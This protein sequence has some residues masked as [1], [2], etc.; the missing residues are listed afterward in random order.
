MRRLASLLLLGL[1]LTGCAAGT[2]NP[3][4]QPNPGPGTQ[5]P[6]PVGGGSTTPAPQPQTPAQTEAAVKAQAVAVLKAIAAND[7]DALSALTHPDKGLR[8]SPYGYVHVGGQDP[9]RV[10][11]AAQIKNAYG[12]TTLLRWGYAD[13]SGEPID[14]SFSQY[15]GGYVNVRD[16]AN[17][18]KS[19]Y[20]TL[21]GQGNTLINLTDVYPN[22]HFVEYHFPGHEK[23]A[24]MD[25]ASLRLVF[26]QKGSTWYL[27]GIC[28]DRWTI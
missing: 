19:G 25:W 21:I 1:L 28:Y 3:A 20:D 26:E 15:W 13:G 16:W 11:T 12:D 18:P 4:P 6:A 5:T 23:N 27:V 22:T 17:A 24:G 14:L 2:K 10:F 8:L 7:M 9:D